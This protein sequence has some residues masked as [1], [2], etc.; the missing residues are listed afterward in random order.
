MILS[1][2]TQYLRYTKP[3]VW[4]LLV[5]SALIG[6][7][8]ASEFQ[9]SFLMFRIIIA[10]VSATLGTA[11]AEAITNYIDRDIDSIMTRTR[12][13][14]LIT[15]EIAPMH[16]LQFGVILA[17]LAMVL[18]IVSHLFYALL[19]LGLGLFDNV[20]IYSYL[21]KRRTP[22]SIILGGFSGGFPV[23][24]GWYCVTDSFS[25]LPW[26][27]FALIVIWIPVHIW[28]LAFRYRED[29]RAAG[30]PMLPVVTKESTTS[31]CVL[32][33]VVFLIFFSVIPFFLGIEGLYYFVVVIVLSSPLLFYAILFLKNLTN[34]SSLVLFKYSNIYLSLTMVLFFVLRL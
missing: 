12:K 17:S 26:M 19:W 7:L 29:Y 32:A 27:L 21:L 24:I 30:V 3:R 31:Q 6:A 20:I 10:V 33:S 8:L 14:P 13:R 4:S 5:F 2:A 23:L 18:L 16:G 34:E 22:W 11:G 9:A 28:S 1:R 25:M 15:G